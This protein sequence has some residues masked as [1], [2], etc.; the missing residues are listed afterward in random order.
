VPGPRYVGARIGLVEPSVGS[1]FWRL[2][3]LTALQQVEVPNYNR[4]NFFGRST[5]V[6]RLG[7]KHGIRATALGPGFVAS[8]MT[9]GVGSVERAAMIAP[10]DLA[11]RVACLSAS[12]N[13]A[14]IAA[15]PVDLR[16]EDTL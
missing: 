1:A 7:W 14:T 15:L 8:D 13:K 4:P 11:A 10:E 5:S 16:Y 12:P 9:A 6:R 2:M 3:G